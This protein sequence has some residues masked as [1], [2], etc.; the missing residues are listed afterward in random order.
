VAL[1]RFLHAD[2]LTGRIGA[3]LDGQNPHASS[4]W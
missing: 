3:L 1:E 4:V 2:G